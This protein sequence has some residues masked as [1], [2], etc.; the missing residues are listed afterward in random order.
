MCEVPSWIESEGSNYWL[1]DKDVI[2]W[3]EENKP[4]QNIN[5]DDFTGHSGIKKVFGVSGWNKEGFPCPDQILNGMLSGKMNEICRHADNI[6][7]WPVEMLPVLTKLS[8]DEDTGVR[9]GVAENT[10]T[11][12]EVLTKLSTDEYSGVRWRVAENTNT[13]AEV[14]T[15]LSTDEESGVRLRVA[16]NTNTPAANGRGF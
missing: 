4:G 3:H 14:L 6:N 1:S 5:W 9:W 10:N 16:E 2:R 8:T 15:K 7:S 13:P 12:A 11:P